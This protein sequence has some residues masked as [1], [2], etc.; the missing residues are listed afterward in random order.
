[1]KIFNEDKNS[2]KLQETKTI[3]DMINESD[4]I[5]TV[6]S[7]IKESLKEFDDE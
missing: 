4:N 6:E 3:T 7:K 2:R 5:P 1:M